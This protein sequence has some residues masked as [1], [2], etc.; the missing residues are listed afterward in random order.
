MEL[1][2]QVV[3]SWKSQLLYL[4]K[5]FHLQYLKSSIYLADFCFEAVQV[6][7]DMVPIL[8]NEFTYKILNAVS[9]LLTSTDLDKRVFICD[10]LEAVARADPSVQFVVSCDPFSLLV[11]LH[12]LC[13]FLCCPYFLVTLQTNAGKTVTGLEC[14]LCY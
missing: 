8:G 12:W 2:I 4:V 3:L 5:N 6:I 1:R 7:R 13:Y 11:V 9:P 10:L 14:N